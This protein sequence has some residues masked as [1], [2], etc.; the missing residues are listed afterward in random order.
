MS[1]EDSISGEQA[2][3]LGMVRVLGV[4]LS[5]KPQKVTGGV[6]SKRQKLFVEM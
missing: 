1:C 5:A 2:G 4:H 6:S 3:M